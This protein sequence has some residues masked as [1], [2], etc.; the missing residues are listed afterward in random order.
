MQFLDKLP[1]EAV[2]EMQH[3]KYAHAKHVYQVSEQ[4]VFLPECKS[5]SVYDKRYITMMV[6]R[7]DIW[8]LS[9][10]MPVMRA[11][12]SINGNLILLSRA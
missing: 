10:L 2:E 1:W 4:F 8:P 7:R 3:R 9:I 12:A 6:R 5:T 11:G